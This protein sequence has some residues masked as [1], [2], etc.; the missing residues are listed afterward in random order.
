LKSD[1]GEPEEIVLEVG[2]LRFHALA[3]GEGPVV[4]CLH[5]FPDYFGS[6]RFQLPALAEAGF[7][8]VSPMLRGY[9]R[10]SQP[11]I[12]PT[13]H[14]K[15]SEFHPLRAADDVVHW[16]RS[17]G[18]G[19]PVHLIGHD[20]GGIITYAVCAL[21]PDVLRSA[22][23][24]AIP[25]MPACAVGIRRHPVQL[26]NS[27][28]TI[29][30]QLRGLADWVVAANDLAFI[31]RL[32]RRWSPG[33]KW[34]PVEMEAVKRTLRAPNAL[35]CAMAYYRA[36]L[37]P[38]SPDSRLFSEVTATSTDVPLLAITGARDG[39][40][41]TRIFDCMDEA[42]FRGGLRIER[43]PAAGHFVHQE[44]PEAVNALL[45]DWLRTHE[46]ASG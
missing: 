21:Y 43:L 29:F 20:W 8:A 37:N 33:W 25:S 6:F 22:C 35:Y 10:S 44:E 41:D 1:R 40:M 3:M 39:C 30:F 2:A 12:G 46:P 32:W 18:Q 36:M 19:Q 23:S 45:V 15:V 5:G 38:F 14:P 17:L 34:D 24:I 7:R 28:Y 4:L 26:L 11:P 13:G 42:Q 9:E 16:A 31:E 27:W